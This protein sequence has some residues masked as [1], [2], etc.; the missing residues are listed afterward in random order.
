MCSLSIKFLCWQE[1]R[2]IF[3]CKEG[4]ACCQGRGCHGDASSSRTYERAVLVELAG[5]DVPVLV[6]RALVLRVQ[7][8]GGGERGPA[9]LHRLIFPTKHTRFTITNFV[10][11]GHGRTD[12]GKRA[13]RKVQL[14]YGMMHL[15]VAVGGSKVSIDLNKLNF[16][17]I[18]PQRNTKQDTTQHQ[19]QRAGYQSSLRYGDDTDRKLK[20]EP[21]REGDTSPPL[22]PRPKYHAS[23][24]TTT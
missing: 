1:L 6:E 19:Q 9:P 8:D 12:Q 2:D 14:P 11:K 17:K 18:N 3:L 13:R 23:L 7:F 22:R 4:Q 24:S 10:F 15:L 20:V 5:V 21:P 16:S